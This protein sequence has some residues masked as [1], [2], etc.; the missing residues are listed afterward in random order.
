MKTKAQLK[1]FRGCPDQS[2]REYQGGVE[3]GGRGLGG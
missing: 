3:R 1:E 2:I